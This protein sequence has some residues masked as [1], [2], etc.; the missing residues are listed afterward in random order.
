MSSIYIIGAIFFLLSIITG[1]QFSLLALLSPLM[2]CIKIFKGEKKKKK[3][4]NTISTRSLT[5]R[6]GGEGGKMLMSK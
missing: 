2:L 6:G 1:R 3:K 5:L 4:F